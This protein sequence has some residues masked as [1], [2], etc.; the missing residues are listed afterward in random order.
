MTTFSLAAW[1]ARGAA[2]VAHHRTVGLK[3]VVL[4]VGETVFLAALVLGLLRWAL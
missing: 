2:G 3:P 1:P 4:M